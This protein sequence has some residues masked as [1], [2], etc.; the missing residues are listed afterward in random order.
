[1]N[2]PHVIIPMAGHGS[3]FADA[4]FETPK[5]LLPTSKDTVMIDLAVS[6]LCMPPGTTY[7]FVVL[8]DSPDEVRV[9]LGSYNPDWVVLEEVSD[10][11]A[12]SAIAG[13]PDRDCPIIVSN[14]DQVLKGWSCSDFITECTGY[15]SGVLT[16]RSEYPNKLGGVDK[17]SFVRL[18]GGECVEFA[19]KIVLSE[20]ALVGVNYF[21]NRET[22]LS[23]YDRMVLEN[24]RAPNGEFYMSLVHNGVLSNGGRV[25]HVPLKDGEEFYPTGEPQ[26]YYAYINKVNYGPTL[27]TGNSGVICDLPHL[28]ASIV[29]GET[30]EEGDLPTNQLVM[31]LMGK[32]AGIVMRSITDTLRGKVLVLESDLFRDAFG[33]MRG[34][35]A[36]TE[37]MVRGWFIGDFL[38]SILRTQEFEVGFG[39]HFVNQ[40]WPYHIHDDMEEYNY[41][42]EGSLQL[43]GIDYHTGDFFMFERG[44]P[45]IPSFATHCKIVCIK[46]PSVRG[47]KRVI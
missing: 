41:V 30:H 20:W 6:T 14:S 40:K 9:R 45:A 3:R 13:L 37:N 38:P 34:K 33:G 5:Y 29:N 31:P 12:T 11:P 32:D 17:N 27:I 21:K 16:Y 36:T 15:D 44:T 1:M 18:E 10:G 7:S 22:F 35:I 43:S 19:E 4:G 25:C 8:K 26:D 28:R 42:L 24:N 39:D 47:D 23:A 2:A 46:S